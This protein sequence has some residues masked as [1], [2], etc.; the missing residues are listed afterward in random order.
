MDFHITLRPQEM[1]NTICK[2]CIFA[3][4]DGITQVDCKLDKIQTYK[5]HGINVK[6][7]Y[8]EDKEFFVL[9]NKRCMFE[10]S[11]NWKHY[12][13]DTAKQLDIINKEIFPYGV[14]II[15]TCDNLS[16]I[17]DTLNSVYSQELLPKY[18]GIINLY[19]VKHY[20]DELIDIFKSHDVP[21]K[22]E[23]IT[24]PQIP[25]YRLVDLIIDFKSIPYY[26]IFYS[27]FKIPTNTFSTIRDKIVNENLTFGALLANS[28][29]QGWT[30]P[31]TIY[32]M[33]GG[34]KQEPL[35]NKLKA[36]K[37]LMIPIQKVV[38]NFPK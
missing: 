33:Y 38:Q 15:N 20:I 18:I 37:C 22:L 14:I 23:N 25:D 35:L 8:D 32:K 34:N 1:V 5:K 29:K 19:G 11:K 2:N 26:S 13:E 27:G 31:Y 6:E 36:D 24:N 30:I 28:N 9:E 3:K 17:S 12:K 10:R 4:Y 7:A 16:K 21:W